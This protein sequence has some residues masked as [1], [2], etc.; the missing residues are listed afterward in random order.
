MDRPGADILNGAVG[1]A[2]VGASVDRILEPRSRAQLVARYELV[3]EA[4][5]RDELQREFAAARERFVEL[6][7]AVLEAT[8]CRTPERHAAQLIALLDG[9]L[10]DQLIG[11]R[12]FL[13][14]DGIR[15]AIE[16][17]MAGC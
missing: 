4:T 9:V 5:R 6:A 13:D 8:G 2:P 11:A 7:G 12:S 16:R 10:V 3:L 15:N 17:Q 14:R 1:R